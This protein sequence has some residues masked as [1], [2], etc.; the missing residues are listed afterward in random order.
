MFN[1]FRKVYNTTIGSSDYELQR[2]YRLSMK[3]KVK[4]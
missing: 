3:Q 2:I 4:Y 1:I